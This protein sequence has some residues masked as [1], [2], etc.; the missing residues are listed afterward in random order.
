[1]GFFVK[2]RRE[3][4]KFMLRLKYKEKKERSVHAGKIAS[5]GKCY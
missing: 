5:L 3:Y 2:V 1:M 4:K